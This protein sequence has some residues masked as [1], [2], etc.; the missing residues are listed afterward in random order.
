MKDEAILQASFGRHSTGWFGR[1]STG[2]FGRHSTG[3]FGLFV[4]IGYRT[5]ATKSVPGGQC[6]NCERYIDQS[7]S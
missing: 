5:Q 4:S 1:H 2:W 3:W 6:M 7:L